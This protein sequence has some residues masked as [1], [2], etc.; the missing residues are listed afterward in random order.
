VGRGW[1]KSHFTTGSHTPLPSKPIRSYAPLGRSKWLNF[2]HADKYPACLGQR[3]SIVATRD[4][5]QETQETQ[6]TKEIFNP[7]EKTVT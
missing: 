4:A 6:E 7:A 1:G 2:C 5:N 3:T